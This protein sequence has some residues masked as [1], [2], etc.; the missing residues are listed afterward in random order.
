MSAL[1][2]M[3]VALGGAIGG[4]LRYLISWAIGVQHVFP[5]ATLS[6]NIAGSF[7]IGLV[8]GMFGHLDWF[9]SWGRLFLVVGVLG[10]FTTFSAFSLETLNLMNDGKATMALAYA[11]T[12][13][14]VCLLAVWLGERTA[15]VA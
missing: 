14:L 5:W 15:Q 11:S 8:W 2:L 12:S 9:Q 10:G 4:V 1:G 13:V 7:A 6:I 3:A